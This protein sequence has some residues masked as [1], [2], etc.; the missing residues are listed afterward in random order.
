M[1][2]FGTKK[3]LK[4]LN[5]CGWCKRRQKGSHA[6]YKKDESK[7]SITIPLN[8]K[9]TKPYI[10]KHIRKLLGLTGKEFEEEI[11]KTM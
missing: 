2:V 7:S 4:L 11:K 6:T 10:V 1:P 3:I 9:E 5:K 8:G